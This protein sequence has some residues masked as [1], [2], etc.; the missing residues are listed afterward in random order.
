M[1]V[2]I[3]PV[4]VV[5][6]IPAPVP[7][8]K[9]GN[10][11]VRV[12]TGKIDRVGRRMVFATPDVRGPTEHV[13]RR[14]TASF[15]SQT[16]RPRARSTK[17]HPRPKYRG[18]RGAWPRKGGRARELS[19]LSQTCAMAGKRFRSRVTGCRCAAGRRATRKTRE[20]RARQRVEWWVESHKRHSTSPTRETYLVR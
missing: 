7:T 17:N 19:S 12:R 2:P 18:R 13:N 8:Q 3:P 6:W 10:H 20:R 15:E 9:R 1:H 5:D 11:G 16:T 14:R 4:F